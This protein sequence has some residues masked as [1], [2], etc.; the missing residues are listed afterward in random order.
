MI[1]MTW[2]GV[3][4]EIVITYLIHGL[5]IGNHDDMERSSSGVGDNLPDPWTPDQ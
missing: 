5:L 2:S 1:M 3:P 4:V